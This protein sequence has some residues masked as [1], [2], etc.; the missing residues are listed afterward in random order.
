MK[1]DDRKI[2]IHTVESDVIV[3]IFGLFSHFHPD[4]NIGVTFGSGK[5]S[6]TIV[7]TLTVKPWV[8]T[9]EKFTLYLLFL[10]IQQ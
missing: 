5:F 1:S 7:S 9:P 2:V 6:V 3:I 8:L 10:C 4:S